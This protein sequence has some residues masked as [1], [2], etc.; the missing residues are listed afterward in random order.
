MSGSLN[1][2]TLIGNLGSN[3]ESHS[4][5]NGG[6]IVRFSIATN[7]SW[8]DRASGERR[9]RVEWHRVAV[10]NPGLATLAEEY[11]RSGAKVLVEGQLRTSKFTDQEGIERY[12]TEVVL[13]G[14]DARMVF[15]DNRRDDDGA[16][17]PAPRNRARAPAPAER[18]MASAGHDDSDIPF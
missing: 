9:E 6:K 11:L 13:N 16:G 15:L 4:F 14:Y 3:P 2:V 10:R 17:G 8:K 7:E 12:S 5:Q 18:E 1:R